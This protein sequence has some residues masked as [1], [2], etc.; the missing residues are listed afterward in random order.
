MTM[1]EVDH[2]VSRK[3]AE[4]AEQLGVTRNRVLSTILC[5]I[6]FNQSL[7]EWQIMGYFSYRV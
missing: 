1:I 4:L 2:D 7:K 6:S 3:L 5:E